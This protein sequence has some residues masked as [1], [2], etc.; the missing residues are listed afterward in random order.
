[1]NTT[2]ISTRRHIRSDLISL[3]FVAFA[4][5]AGMAGSNP[6]LAADAN[7]APRKMTVQYA[8]LNLSSAQ[9]VE[10]LYFRIVTAADQVCAVPGSKALQ[11]WLQARICTRQSIERAVAAVGLPA[12]TAFHAAKTGQP[13]LV[14]VATR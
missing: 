3:A 11:H 6:V 7:T 1:M 5:L 8:D 4:G 13:T 14:Q 10:E 12:L 9:G 2:Q